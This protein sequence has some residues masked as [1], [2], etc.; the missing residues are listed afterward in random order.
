MSTPV[1]GLARRSTVHV[2]FAFVAMGGWAVFANRAHAMPAPLVAGMIQ[3]GLS[4]LITL[5]LKLMIETL[6]LHLDG[7]AALLVPPVITCLVSASLLTL[8]HVLSGTPEVLA[9]IALPLTVATSY[10]ALYN[11]SLWKARRR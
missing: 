11:F 3:G 8:I 1:A 2:L 6:S 10:A 4:A 7:I 5:F 9:T